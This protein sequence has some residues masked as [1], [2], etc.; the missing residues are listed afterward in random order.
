MKFRQANR[1]IAKLL[2][3]EKDC[4][5]LGGRIECSAPNELLHDF[6][7]KYFPDPNDSSKFI[8]LDKNCLLL[9]GCNL[10]QTFCIYGIVVYLGHNTKMMK[11]FP[12]FKYKTATI[13]AVLNVHILFLF[14]LDLLL[15]LFEASAVYFDAKVINN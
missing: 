13:E 1:E 3:Y 6:A 11:N 9:R 8:M 7:A 4:E 14:M 2:L 12:N 15:C 5:N 10:K